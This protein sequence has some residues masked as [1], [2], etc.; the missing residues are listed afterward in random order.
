MSA[1]APTIAPSEVDAFD[2]GWDYGC[3]RVRPPADLPA[4]GYQGYK[5]ALAQTHPHAADR[6]VRKWLLVRTN[7][8]RRGMPFDPA[9]TPQAIR[10]LDVPTCPVTGETLS[11]GAKA[12]SD[13][14]VD[15][16]LNDRGY[17]PGN[18]VMM[19]T[20]ANRAKA[21]LSAAEIISLALDEASDG[22]GGLSRGAWISMAELVNVFSIAEHGAPPKG[23]ARLLGQM[24][25]PGLRLSALAYWQTKVAW[26]AVF[27]QHGIDLHKPDNLHDT[28]ATRRAA[29]RLLGEILCRAR[30]YTVPFLAWRAPRMQRLLDDLIAV[31]GPEL[32]ASYNDASQL[33]FST[34]LQE[35]RRRLDADARNWLHD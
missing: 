29:K 30:R 26:Q 4:D 9:L 28:K 35:R 8:L 3:H 32:F 1:K 27:G 11:H 24:I 34:G 21:D 23:V 33:Y 15:R 13:W 20:R 31:G 18:M 5:A 25:Y 22:Y 14:S 12:L 6:F 7:A 2:L 17:L 10:G 16:V 19:S